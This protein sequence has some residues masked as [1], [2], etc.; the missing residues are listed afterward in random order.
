MTAGHGFCQGFGHGLADGFRE[1]T[2]FGRP[3]RGDRFA[4]EMTFATGMNVALAGQANRLL[5]A[6]DERAS[7]V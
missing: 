4:D 5:A 7:G 6:A 2:G 1:P 3:F